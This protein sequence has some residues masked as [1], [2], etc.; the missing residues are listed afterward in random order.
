MVEA[1]FDLGGRVTV[2]DEFGQLWAFDRQI[3]EGGQG[4]VW[5]AAGGRAAIKIIG[6]LRG[7]DEARAVYAKLQRV[8]RLP[9]EGI[10][11]AGVQALLAPPRVGYIM[12]LAGEMFE[13]SNLQNVPVD[14]DPGQWYQATGGL[15][16]R[17]RL[18]A[19]LADSVARLHSRAIAFQ[20]LSPANVLISRSADYD[21]LRLIDVDN[22]AVRSTVSE[23]VV[24]TP[25]Y[26]APEVVSGASGASTLADAHAL[27]I[28][29]FQT[30]TTMHPF[31][32]DLVMDSPPEFQQEQAD[33]YLVPWIDHPEDRSNAT[34][35]GIAPRKDLL[36]SRLWELCRRAFVDGIADPLT[37]PSAA[38]WA[39]ALYAAADQTIVC[40]EC[41]WSFRAVASACF[42]CGRPPDRPWIL[43]YMMSL[44]RELVDDADDDGLTPQYAKLPEFSVLGTTG[45]TGI[46]ARHAAVVP[47]D[48]E[49]PVAGMRF[50]HGS[51][52]VHNYSRRDL[53]VDRGDGAGP[54][55]VGPGAAASTRAG[56]L[57]AGWELHF[58]PPSST[59]RWAVVNQL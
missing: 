36:T 13:L 12:E 49:E 17:L 46:L 11:I 26:G 20:D 42:C 5:L 25:G 2:A 45:E 58:G 51:M 50:E 16:R 8:R 40:A 53:W 33:R 7:Q 14:E 6:G 19:R 10:R 31:R 22:L 54:R 32:G 37:R 52:T 29:I 21:E 35:L 15:A 47:E 44:G 9:L 27:A 24:W 3:G 23:P 48:P 39:A 28:L 41:G 18:M 57:G 55:R 56:N 34:D 38:Q 43:R 4:R 1:V 30:L 59:H